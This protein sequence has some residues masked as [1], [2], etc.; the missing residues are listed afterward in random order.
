MPRQNELK[1]IEII[2]R[3]KLAKE[4]H[5]SALRKNAKRNY[6]KENSIDEIGAN[7]NISMVNSQLILV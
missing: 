6:D 5:E 7:R 4:F 3:M 1:L 2:L